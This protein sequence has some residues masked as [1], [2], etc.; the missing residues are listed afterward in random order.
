MSF[1]VS[2]AVGGQAVVL[3]AIHRGLEQ[4]GPSPQS[5]LDPDAEGGEQDDSAP[6]E[7]GEGLEGGYTLAQMWQLESTDSW[8]FKAGLTARACTRSRRAPARSQMQCLLALVW[9]KPTDLHC[10]LKWLTLTQQLLDDRGHL[11]AG[12]P[13]GTRDK[14]PTRGSCPRPPHRPL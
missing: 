3:R 12:H 13:S 4:P 1:W 14:V 2:G 8:V 6:E 7:S 11:P 5:G 9:G 10:N